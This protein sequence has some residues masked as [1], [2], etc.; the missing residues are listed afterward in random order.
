MKI[1][2]ALDCVQYE[3]SSAMCAFQRREDADAFVSKCTEYH[4]TRPKCPAIDDPD[5]VWDEYFIL[6]EKWR[7]AHPASKYSG[8]GADYYLV[9]E[10]EFEQRS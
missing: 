2:L 6:E 3:G 10:V 4:A 8:V 5:P 1:Y 9:R 7:E